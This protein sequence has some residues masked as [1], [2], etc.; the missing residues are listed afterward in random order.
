MVND[1][2]LPVRFDRMLGRFSRPG[3]RLPISGL[4]IGFRNQFERYVTMFTH[5]GE[6]VE[7][8]VT[9]GE[10]VKG[11]LNSLLGM[12]QETGGL[13]MMPKALAPRKLEQYLNFQAIR[14][15]DRLLQELTLNIKKAIR[16]RAD[17]GLSDP[18]T[19]AELLNDSTA[20]QGEALY[21]RNMFNRAGLN[22]DAL[23]A[24]LKDNPERD[25]LNPS[26]W[27]SFVL[28]VAKEM[29][30]PASDNRVTYKSG[31]ARLMSSLMGYGMWYN[32]RLAETLA[33][34]SRKKFD[35]AAIYRGMFFLGTIAA[36]GVMVGTPI[37]RLIKHLLYD[38]EDQTGKFSSDN[39]A[40]RNAGVLWEQTAPFWPIIGS[41][42]SQ[43][44]DARSGGGKLFNFL[45]VSIA[46]QMLQTANEIGQTGDAF[47]PIM[48]VLRQLSP[49]TKVIINNLPH[50]EGLVEVNSAARSLR[51]IAA[52]DIEVRTPKSG[53]AIRYS[54]VSTQIQMAVNE[55][56]TDDPD[57]EAIS[58]YRDD[59]VKKLVRAGASKED[60]ERR[61]DLSVLARFPQN[62]VY[63]RTLT[64]GEKLQQLG[65]LNMDQIGRLKR[66]EDSFDRYAT[67][68][69]LRK[70][71]VPR[72]SGSGSSGNSIRVGRLGRRRS[73]RNTFGRITRN[74]RIVRR[75]R[76]LIRY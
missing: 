30:M 70:P 6:F 35:P 9:G 52:G 18:I 13:I 8:E 25:L 63:G 20:K 5:G 72:T 59:A 43:L 41:V 45:P 27:N 19:D 56:A 51:S 1:S 62:T 7:T 28:E 24:R 75:P 49:N 58:R 60:A 4:Y 50:M 21:M 67:T 3:L 68:Y 65:R 10:K 57:Y 37:Q 54:P 38:E 12:F 22:I 42:M 76:R 32:E 31:F 44:Y 15:A 55:M 16:D 48:K 47:Y 2:E 33:G 61:F 29:N 40:W 17:L 36:M 23:A 64:A 53:G 73:R 39:T 66:V 14:H 74:R 69:G 11:G 34:N 26:E 71:S 46:S